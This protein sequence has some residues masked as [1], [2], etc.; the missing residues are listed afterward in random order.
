MLFLETFVYKM[1]KYLAFSCILCF[2]TPATA[3]VRFQFDSFTGDMVRFSA[4]LSGTV[5]ST[6]L[7]STSFNV[8]IVMFV[9]ALFA[10]F[11]DDGCNFLRSSHYWLQKNSS[12]MAIPKGTS[13]PG[14]IKSLQFASLPAWGFLIG[15][16]SVKEGIELLSNMRS[17]MFSVLAFSNDLFLRV[18]DL[19][20]TPISVQLIAIYKRANMLS[21][22]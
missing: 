12:E 15:E 6:N 8:I 17:K 19:S 2:Y 22:L 10:N 21:C 3:P 1:V 5:T 13:A 16:L 14:S 7:I 11:K 4:R 18:G 20:S 9:A